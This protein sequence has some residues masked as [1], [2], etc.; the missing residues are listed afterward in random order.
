LNAPLHL[1]ARNQLCREIVWPIIA[2][3]GIVKELCFLLEEELKG[4]I[5]PDFLRLGKALLWPN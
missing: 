1:R 2:Q 5:L 4:D 3:L